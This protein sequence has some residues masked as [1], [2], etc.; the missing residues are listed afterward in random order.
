MK[1]VI[2][3]EFGGPEVL[4]IAE[5][6]TPRPGPGQMLIQV[7][8]AG[9]NPADWKDR[10][11]HVAGF[12]NPSFPY[13]MGFDVAGRVVEIG[14]GVMNFEVGDRVLAC[15]D[16]GQ[17]DFG[18][19]AEYVRVREQ[20]S[21]RLPGGLPF[22]AGA[23]MPVA[24]LT[25]WQA[26]YDHAGL[27]AGQRVLIHGA[28]GGVGSFAVQF[29]RHSGAEVASICSARNLDYVRALGADP[30]FDYESDDMPG[31][32]DEWA[33]GGLHVIVDA[34]GFGTLPSPW[35]LLGAGGKLISIATL[36]GDG[37]IEGDMKEAAHRSREK[38]F[39]IMVDAEAG[40]PLSEIA[41]LVH[42]G[43]VALPPIEVFSLDRVAEAHALLE[44]GH[45]RGKLVLELAGE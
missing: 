14:E 44:S 37:D 39:A 3:N 12:T 19:Y 40:G 13:V 43:A 31:Q 24:A 10:E 25:A 29:A 33:Q 6:E 38:I 9:M 18:G 23:S 41:T 17:G 35:A 36:L 16:H 7:A 26:L 2:L 45:V 8:Y 21:A 20:K 28:S 22:K 32:L 27:E 42:Q 11:G 4:E 15:T 5:V 34:V 30:C 1:A